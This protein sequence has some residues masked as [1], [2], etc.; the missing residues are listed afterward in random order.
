MPP[1]SR[2]FA[3]SRHPQCANASDHCAHLT[4][5]TITA[6]FC[7]PSI[8]N[9]WGVP[10]AL[11]YVKQLVGPL[12]RA[13]EIESRTTRTHR[14]EAAGD[15]IP[16]DLDVTSKTRVTSAMCCGELAESVPAGFAA[17]RNT[18]EVD[19]AAS[20]LLEAFRGGLEVEM[21][22]NCSARQSERNRMQPCGRVDCYSCLRLMLFANSAAS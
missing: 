1:L 18:A 2:D 5:C 15:T 22:W 4:S 6:K 20:G 16:Q 12:V 11:A 13:I 7:F 8:V 10:V 19:G 17:A 21:L 14:L 9:D 3:S